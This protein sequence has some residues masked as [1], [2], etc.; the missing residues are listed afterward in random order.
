MGIVMA[1][2][3]NL[4]QRGKSLDSIHDSLSLSILIFFFMIF[5]TFLMPRV[6]LAA[7]GDILTV[8]GNGKLATLSY[9]SG[10]YVDS[11]GN[12]YIADT[13]NHLIRRVDTSG[14]ITTVAGD[15]SYGYSGDNGP[16]T[17][18]SLYYPTSVAVDSAGNLYIADIDNNR[19]RKVDTGGVI[20][21]VAGNGI[22]GYS[23]DNG[24]ATS[25]NLNLPC[26]VAVDGL[27]NLYIA[28]YYNDRIRKVDTS[29]IITTVAGNGLR[30][31]IGDNG[32]ATS[33]SLFDPMS[34]V[35]DSAGNL[36]VADTWHN[37]IRKVDTGGVITTVAG[38]GIQGYSGDNGPATS[39]NL[40][41]PFGVAVD[42]VGNLYIADFNNNRIRMVDTN[43]I[44][45]TVAGDGSYGYSG[46]NGPAIL[47]SLFSP[48]GVAVDSAGNIYIADT[49]N[50]CIRK[51]IETVKP[52]GTLAINGG[53]ATVY[54]TIVTLT[55]SCSDMGGSCD[56][57]QFSND[58]VTYTAPETY[59]TT[60]SW[61]LTSG[62]GSKTVYAKYKDLTGN[63][64]DPVS[65]TVLLVVD[66]TPPSTT[67]T[68]AGGT[69]TSAQSVTL[70][71][72]DS[73]GSGCMNTYYCLGAGCSPTTSYAGAILI[74]SSSSLSFYST[75]ITGN[76]E[77]IKSQTYVVAT[78]T[79]YTVTA[80]AGLNGSISPSG[81]VIVL[82]G[83]SQTFTISP[84]AGYR[85]S[86]VLVDGKSMGATTLYTFSK[87][88]GNHTINASFTQDVYTITITAG[89]NG[90][91]S[92]AGTITVNPGDNATFQIT[93]SPGHKIQRVLV[94]GKNLGVITSYTFAN[95]T[96]NH[97][98]NASFK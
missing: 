8:A 88:N 82:K 56:Q 68:P 89:P 41:Q 31:Y 22:Q 40:K 61:S 24:P 15:G 52:K 35:V 4:L 17:S 69:Y 46:D 54:S 50:Q 48:N 27:G 75:D 14:V 29:G 66:T 76:V 72:N 55:L 11:A 90:S 49:S 65:A 87:V 45:T 74:N 16:A 9:P 85:V 33:A 34:V 63:W 43:G 59:S 83:D 2:T 98:I 67:A 93:P 91:I 18:A 36:Y 1:R 71:C 81:A 19:I 39:A 70:S 64:S 6:S 84:A 60:A 10:I 57:M 20:T 32:P 80:T 21:T 97:T 96:T 44:I 30:D 77:T 25:A 53:V 58:N 37:R 12:L 26:G 42:S 13:Y 3:K 95:V 92:P 47:A 79:T 62:S 38:N 51:V 23:G 5:L 78:G 28:D 7:P 73:G 86:D 94:D